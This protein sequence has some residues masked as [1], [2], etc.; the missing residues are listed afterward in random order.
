MLRNHLGWLNRL[1]FLH[2][3]KT[4]L[5]GNKSIRLNWPVFLRLKTYLLLNNSRSLNRLVFLRR[6]KTYLLRNN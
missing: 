5:L 6:V 1:V 4:Y 3:V 2:R